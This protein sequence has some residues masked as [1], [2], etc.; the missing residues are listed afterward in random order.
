[1]AFSR[2]MRT[3]N[4]ELYKNWWSH[5]EAAKAR[6]MGEVGNEVGNG[7]QAPGNVKAKK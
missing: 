7:A 2:D 4:S 6:E 3:V 1:M 5:A